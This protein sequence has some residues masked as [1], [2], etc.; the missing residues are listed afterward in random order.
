MSELHRP[1]LLD[2]VLD[3]LQI[4]AGGRY[5]D[6][7]F[8][9]GGHAAAMLERLGTQ[10]KLL[11]FD[12]DPDALDYAAQRFPAES[13]LIMHRGSFG[14]LGTVVSELGWQG[15]VDGVLLDLGVSSPQLD[16]AGR[17]FSFLADG[18]LDM[19]MNP[20]DGISAADWLAGAAERDIAEVLWKY[21]EERYARRIARSIVKARD[22]APIA[23]TS[24]LAALIAAAVPG[25]EPKKHPATR[26]FQAI[27]IFINQE[28][29]DLEAVLPQA[30]EAL[31]PG[32]RLA[33]ISFHSLEDRIV[34]RFIRDQHRGPA[35][36]PGLPVM[37][38]GYRPRLKPVGKQIRA[39]KSEVQANPRARSAVLRVAE[40][41]S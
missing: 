26:S 1:V 31:A 29:D 16:D 20:Q 33:V 36:P 7:T 27:R 17:G 38:A 2:Q 39:D 35:L 19:R 41:L 5:V 28:L 3:A 22:E 18:P 14:N 32:G 40:R 11:A 23:S 24:R 9:R 6:G 34:K 37:P 8:G 30:V 10:G 21:G 4:K 13:R 25:R 15:R 12:K